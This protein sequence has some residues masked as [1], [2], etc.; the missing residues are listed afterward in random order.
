MDHQ[1]NSLESQNNVPAEKEKVEKRQDQ[2]RELQ[3]A[4]KEFIEG[5]AEVVEDVESNEIAESTSEDKK[6]GPQGQ[7]PAKS[8]AKVQIQ[9]PPLIIPRIEVMQIQIATAIKKEIAVLEKEAVRVSNN[10]F[11]LTGVVLKIRQLKDI[12]ANLIHAPLDTLKGWWM[13]Y[14]NKSS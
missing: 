13:K 8:G 2:S 1:R 3:E 5:V 11:A 6:K 9:L 14:V 12:L 7:F 10:P 4:S